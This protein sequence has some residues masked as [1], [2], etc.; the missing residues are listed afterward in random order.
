MRWGWIRKVPGEM[1][2]QISSEMPGEMSGEMPG[3]ILVSWGIAASPARQ[4]DAMG[5][6]GGWDAK[7]LLTGPE[8]LPNPPIPQPRT[9]ETPKP[10]TPKTSNP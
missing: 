7:P 2:G 10:R 3:E 9:T 8:V 5:L 4:V 6:D 1:P